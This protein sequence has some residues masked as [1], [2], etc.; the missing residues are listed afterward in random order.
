MNCQINNQIIYGLG[1]IKGVGNAIIEII[2]EERIS[3]NSKN[4]EKWY[5]NLWPNLLSSS[6]IYKISK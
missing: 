2:I 1:A 3:V 6:A 4:E 5:L